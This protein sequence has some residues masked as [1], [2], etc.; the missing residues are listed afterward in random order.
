MYNRLIYIIFDFIEVGVVRKKQ[1]P[2]AP[3]SNPQNNTILKCL[4]TPKY[5]SQKIR[6]AD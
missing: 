1:M 5:F 6:I 4:A 2:R 3:F